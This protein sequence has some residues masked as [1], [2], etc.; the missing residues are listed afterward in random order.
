MSGQ[1]G[2]PRVLVTGAAGFVG[3]HLVAALARALPPGS[4]VLA[5]L[6]GADRAPDGATALPFDVTDAAGTREAVRAA[7]PTCVV[8]LAAIAA[9]QEARSD[10]ARTW[11]INVE[12]TM[13]L[14]AA[15]L[16]EAPGARFLF[17][18]TSE[19]YG[20]TFKRGTAPLDEGALLDPT[21]PYAASKAAADL[22]IGQM[23]RDG[24]KAVRMRP[25]NHTGPGQSEA[26]VVPAFAAQIA[27][28]EAGRQAPVMKVGNLEALRDF[29]DV[30][31]VAAAYAAAVLAPELEPGLILNVASGRPRPIRDALDALTALAR[32]PVSVEPDPERMRPNDT[33]F[34]VGDA[35]RAKN[36]LGWA[37]RIAWETTIADTLDFWRERVAREAS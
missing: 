35:T 33:P 11:R 17:V 8:H 30:R 36:L 21:N 12:G 7:R 9:L 28:I 2:A 37:P 26:F 15:T 31:D 27:R 3:G 14:A 4:T 16:S 10:P 34:A 19:V 18:S 23:A 22:L 25:F 24:L 29:L 20:G 32:V 1:E 5:G 13:N 6:R